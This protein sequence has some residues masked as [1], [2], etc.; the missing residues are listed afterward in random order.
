[1]SIRKVK[2]CRCSIQ[3]QCGNDFPSIGSL[4]LS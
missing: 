1:L 2:S 4:V 3:K